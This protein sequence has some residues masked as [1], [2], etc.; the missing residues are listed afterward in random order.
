METAPLTAGIK[1][2][3]SKL[4]T[5]ADEFE[6]PFFYLSL[7]TPSTEN[8]GELVAGSIGWTGNFKFAFELD[9]RH[10]LRIFQVLILLHQ[11]IS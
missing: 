3:D 6:A 5:R 11:N 7:N 8:T 10:D 4:G 1:V 2:I 9:E